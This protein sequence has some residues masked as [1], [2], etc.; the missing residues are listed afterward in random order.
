MKKRKIRIRATA[1][2]PASWLAGLPSPFSEIITEQFLQQWL[3]ASNRAMAVQ[4]LQKCSSCQGHGT[5]SD[6]SRCLTCNG[7]DE[8]QR[9]GT[10]K[11]Q[12]GNSIPA[13][14]CR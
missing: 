3:D 7:S 9:G 8:V 6:G 10:E 5:C 12:R 11:V 2:W 4:R 14:P 13:I 1:A